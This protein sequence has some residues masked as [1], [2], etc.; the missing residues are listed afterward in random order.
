MGVFSRSSNLYGVLDHPMVAA[1]FGGLAAAITASGGDA[2]MYINNLRNGETNIQTLSEFLSMDLSSRYLNPEW[3]KGMMESGY[4]GTAH[5][6]E[7]FGV[8]SVWQMT[9]PDLVTD[10]M[11][12]NLYETYINDSKETGVTEYLKSE[13]AYAYQSAVATLLNSIY[14]G[15]WTPSE[16]VQKQLEQEYVEQTILN[17]VVCCH[18]T[19][20]NLEL[21]AQIVQGLL[22]MDISKSEKQTYLDI[23]NVALDQ[24]FNLPTTNSG[25]GSGTGGAVVVGTADNETNTT[26]AQTEDTTTDGEG[27]GQDATPSGSTASAAPQVSGYEMVTQ[28]MEN[29]AS[30]VRDFIAN[31]TVSS[32]SMIA[33]AFVVLVIGA[34]FFGF[35]RKGI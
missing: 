33:I 20:S 14:S 18:H 16:D 22:S 28:R 29:A 12:N 21:N 11:W 2:N 9:M 27:F 10:K 24:N 32:S 3:I 35:R 25:S 26:L 8:M 13:N 31:P 4:A 23:I 34:V 1:Y 15:D 17:G 30:S 7:L 6:E 19:C 5:M